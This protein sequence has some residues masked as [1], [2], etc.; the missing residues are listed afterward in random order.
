MP[1]WGGKGDSF[2]PDEA[3]AAR[4]KRRQLEGSV[5]MLSW[6]ATIDAFQHWIYAHPDQT[7]KEREAA[8]VE[9]H[10]RFAP[11]LDWRGIEEQRGTLW[12]AQRHIFKA[13]F[14][15]IE[16]GIALLGALQLWR[17]YR[18]DPSAAVARYRG[19]LALGG[20]RPLPELFGAAGIEFAMDESTLRGV[21]DDLLEGIS[22]ET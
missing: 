2:Y 3:D 11:S 18:R 13:P 17:N 22:A 4:A 1:Y 21:V 10:Q 7:G 14:Y 20:T 8:W 5:T 9:V 19:A 6:I 16:Y 12:H 15:Y